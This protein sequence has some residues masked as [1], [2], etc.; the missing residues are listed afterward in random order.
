MKTGNVN[1]FE[2]KVPKNWSTQYW[3]HIKRNI[4]IIKFTEQEKLKK[5]RVGVFG[6]GGLGGPLIENLVRS[7]CE[8]LVI[9][10]NDI[11]SESN[12]NRQ[13]CTREDIGE[14]KVDVIENFLYKINPDLNINKY[15]EIIED[16]LIEVL[17]NT[18]I[19]ALTLDDPIISILIS[20]ECRKR[21]I[22]MIESWGIPYLFAWWFTSKSIDYEN[23][24]G[25]NTHNM[26]IEDIQKSKSILQEIKIAQLNYLLKFPNI[27]KTYDREKGAVDGMIEGKIA[28][29]SLAPVVHMTAAYL[30]FEIIVSGILEIKKMILAPQIIGY[31]YLKMKPL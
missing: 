12:L 18:H 24:Y 15:Y 2:S 4:G 5:T 14:Y 29:V 16:N 21:S 1:L 17:K 27:R 30:S 22:P 6:L 13:L 25:L 3:N 19:V 23:C 28:L 9:C 26:K 31:D 8:N 11:F 10:D 7:G 20:R